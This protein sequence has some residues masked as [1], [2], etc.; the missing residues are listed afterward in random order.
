[1]STLQPAVTPTFTPVSTSTPQPAPTAYPTVSITPTLLEICRYENIAFIGGSITAG[2]GASE[3]SKSY[4]GM[5]G[6]WFFDHCSNIIHIKNISIGG[7]GSDFG[8]YRL[9]HD[10]GN[11][12]PDI[13]FYEFAVNDSSRP[14]DD[15]KKHIDSLI[16]KLRRINSKM[17]IFSVLTT[18]ASH[19]DFYRVGAL[20]PEVITHIQAASDNNI[21]VIN[22]GQSLWTDVIRYDKNIQEYIS[23][24]VHPNDSGYQHYYESVIQFLDSY[25][26][27][28]AEQYSGDLANATL[29]DLSEVTSTSCEK[30]NENHEVHLLCDNGDT[31]SSF[32]TGDVLGVVGRIRSD[33]GRLECTLDNSIKTTLDFWDAYAIKLDRTSYFFPFNGLEKIKHELVCSVVDQRISSNAGE[34]KGYAVNILYFMVNP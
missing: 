20:P 19:G 12:I 24:G 10:L 28:P 21:P 31:F 26:N 4:A 32:F 2:A 22:V 17:L 25:F 8:V 11:F 34:S 1:M 3:S 14:P 23:D 13:T 15:I 7:T 29:M 33:G 30:I 16:Y 6:K 5:V 18:R 27:L 9:E